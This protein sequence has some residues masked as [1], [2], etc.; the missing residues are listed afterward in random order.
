MGASGRRWRRGSSTGVGERR[1]SKCRDPKAVKAEDSF[2]VSFRPKRATRS[3]AVSRFM[4]SATPAPSRR[5][6]RKSVDLEALGATNELALIEHSLA[7]GASEVIRDEG[8]DLEAG[9]G[10][11][12]RESADEKMSA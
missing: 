10:G 5:L 9:L 7:Q 12:A 1:G 3:S 8:P 4:Q 2:G 11:A 6:S